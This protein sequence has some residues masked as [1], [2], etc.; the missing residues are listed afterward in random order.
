M[1]GGDERTSARTLRDACAI[2]RLGRRRDVEHL[3]GG[4]PGPHGREL[5]HED[6]D[7]V[8]PAHLTHPIERTERYVRKIGP[9]VRP[10]HADRH[11]LGPDSAAVEFADMTDRVVLRA[12]GTSG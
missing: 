1:T 8:E 4:S 11:D 12:P 3:E 5:G 7:A 9:A 6:D 2:R 10:D